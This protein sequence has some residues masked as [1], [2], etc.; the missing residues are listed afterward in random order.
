M[1]CPAIDSIET[2]AS[3][4]GLVRVRV[5]RARLGPIRREDATRI[6]LEEGARWTR[7]LE[8]KFREITDAMACRADALR[9][10][11]RRDHSRALLEARLS[12]RWG[13]SIAAQVVK[14]LASEGWLDD[15]A[16]AER[17]VESLRRTGP[18]ARELLRDRLESEGVSARHASQASGGPDDATALVPLARQW[19]RQGRSAPWI[20]R[21]LGR[22]GFDSD[23]IASALQGAGLPCPFED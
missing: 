23:T 6:G 21:A 22:R 19:K 4:P 16:Y 15:R 9:R 2:D 1:T 20:A 12:P 7:A 13:E 11:G 17:R 10:L 3:D 8:R 14:D 18:L 5:G